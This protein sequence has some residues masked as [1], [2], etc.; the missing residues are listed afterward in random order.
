MQPQKLMSALLGAVATVVVVLMGCGEID[1]GGPTSCTSDGSCQTGEICHPTAKICVKTCTQATDCPST[2]P[3]CETFSGASAKFCQCSTTAACGGGTGST[4]ICSSTDR[5]CA[6]KCG[7]A[8]DCGGRS[9][10]ATTGECQNSTLGKTCSTAA[11]QPDTCD[12][13]QACSGSSPVC[14]AVT[15]PTCANFTGSNHATTWLSTNNAPVIYEITKVSFGTST[16][17]DASVPV[18]A[19]IHVKAYSKSGQLL[20]GAAI[21]GQFHY[22]RAAGGEGNNSGTT[23][24]VNTSSDGKHTEFDMNFCLPSGSTQVTIGLHFVVSGVTG[25]EACFV[26]Q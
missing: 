12:N 8:T 11:V 5:I 21:E 26:V 7:S 23:Q 19:R 1:P 2:A 15:A 9:C 16:F 17:C 13:G 6:T 3:T 20:P 24:N 14:T 10:N 4:T 22:V 18:R 25:N